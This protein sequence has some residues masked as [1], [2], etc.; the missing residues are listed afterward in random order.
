MT[1]HI[2]G[3]IKTDTLNIEKNENAEKVN[4]LEKEMIVMDNVS[5]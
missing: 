5:S 2:D 3:K 4:S 1:I